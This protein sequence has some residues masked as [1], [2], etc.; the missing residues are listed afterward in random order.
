MS[1]DMA[2]NMV[3]DKAKFTAKHSVAFN[4]QA[5]MIQIFNFMNSF[6]LLIF[7]N[8]LLFSSKMSVFLTFYHPNSY[9]PVGSDDR[10]PA[11]VYCG[12]YRAYKF[13]EWQ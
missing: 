11:L 5:F 6:K 13:S 2:C 10:H 3:A 8:F 12:E 1:A 7:F 9:S 4:V